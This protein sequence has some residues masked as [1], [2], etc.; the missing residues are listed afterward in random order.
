MSTFDPDKGGVLCQGGPGAT[1]AEDPSDVPDVG[2][3][4]RL[5]LGVRP[6]LGLR[7]LQPKHVTCVKLEQRKTSEVPWMEYIPGDAC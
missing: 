4:R 7:P 2:E 6:I 5:D 1:V 3:M